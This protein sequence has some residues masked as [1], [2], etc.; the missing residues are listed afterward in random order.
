MTTSQ[1]LLNLGLLGYVLYSNLGTR[2]LTRRR[3][4]LP[5]LIVAVAGYAFLRDIPTVGH[6]AQ[7]ELVGLAAGAVL[8]VVAALLVR[9]RRSIDGRLIATAGGA[10]AALWIAVIGG[11]MLFAYGADHWFS[12][13]IVQFSRQHE[14]TGAG[15]WTVAFVL[16]AL[17]MVVVRVLVTAIQA[18]RTGAGRPEV[19]LRSSSRERV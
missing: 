2:T 7:L 1:Y 10:F 4:T 11:R 14:I 18:A 5:L 17:T 3:F 13:T 15:A 8:G 19:I 12:S 9:V 6:D 16:M